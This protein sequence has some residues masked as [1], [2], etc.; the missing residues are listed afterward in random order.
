MLP[1]RQVKGYVQQ[2]LNRSMTI[3]NCSSQESYNAPFYSVPTSRCHPCCSASPLIICCHLDAGT[4]QCPREHELPNRTDDSEGVQKRPIATYL[5]RILE[6]RAQFYHLG[7]IHSPRSDREWPRSSLPE[8]QG[9]LRPVRYS[10]LGNQYRKNRGCWGPSKG[11]PTN[12]E[13]IRN[14]RGRAQKYCFSAVVS[15]RGNGTCCD[16][17]TRVACSARE[18]RLARH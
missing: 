9:F 13:K 8:S 6:K 11:S 4:T 18:S 16:G 1:S 3:S 2:Y 10:S 17:Y 12:D 14:N 15:F 7:S 5:A